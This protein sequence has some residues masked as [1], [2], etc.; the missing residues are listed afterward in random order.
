METK[1]QLFELLYPSGMPYP[2]SHI[3]GILNRLCTSNNNLVLTAIK[4]LQ[5]GSLTGRE[6][7]RRSLADSIDDTIYEL[8]YNDGDHYQPDTGVTS[9]MHQAWSCGN[10]IEE[11]SIPDED[12]ED[13][14]LIFSILRGSYNNPNDAEW[15]WR[16]V[17]ALAF[18]DLWINEEALD[19]DFDFIEFAGTHDDIAL[20][21]STA[22]ERHTLN[23]KLLQA[24][25]SQSSGNRPLCS[26]SL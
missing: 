24:V 26:G 3:N 25:I 8:Q 1:S 14:G 13:L 11:A 20:V 18:T 15:Y 16:G 17:A 10:V 21:I 7:A 9:R 6:L 4:L 12:R 2:M 22:K 5:K 23:C 19:R